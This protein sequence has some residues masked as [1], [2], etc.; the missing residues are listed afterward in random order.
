M[1]EYCDILLTA[2]YVLTQNHERE[3]IEQG[4]VAVAGRQI[5]ALG[6]AADLDVR[7]QAVQRIDLGHSLLMPAL[8]NAHTHSPMTLLRGVAD[9]LPLLEW[10]TT[11]I[12]PLEAKLTEE[13]VRLGSLLACAEMLRTGTCC[14]M[15]MYF[16]QDV[17]ASVVDQCGMRAVLAEGLLAF[18]TLSYQNTEQAF[19]IIEDLFE[20]FAD[21]ERIHFGLAPHTVF[22]ATEEQI[23][24]SFTLA[25]K[26]DTVWF[27]HCAET[28]RETAECLKKLGKRPVA[29]LNDM[30][31]LSPRSVLVHAVDLTL[32]EIALLAETG[33]KV[34]L[35]PK[36][37]MKLASGVAKAGAM[38]DAGLCP[39]LGTDGAASNNTL[40]MFLEMNACALL[41]KVATLDP[42][43]LHAPQVL[44][45]ATINSAACVGLPELGSLTPGGP[46]DLIALDL[47]VPNMI[48]VHNPLSHL[49][50]A[51]NGSEV[52]LTMVDGRI[53]YRDGRF[54][55]L[56]YP[57]L[58]REMDSVLRWAGKQA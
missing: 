37:N 5:L 31:L 22:T 40:N 16:H 44:D 23:V 43:L 9:D 25:E 42:T 33:S 24:R 21:H 49:V 56:D 6:P 14:F 17:T 34:V 10:L 18:P 19:E 47:Q 50:Y 30:G 58:L 46:A 3:I 7:F 53:C 12:W 36:S 57:A 13:L 54:L 38:L 1:P 4:A 29:F 39:G 8:V 32:D 28:P 52:R 11:R 45:M 48:P 26:Y 15:D 2:E 51:A 20:R 41:Q 27:T 55:T 35:A